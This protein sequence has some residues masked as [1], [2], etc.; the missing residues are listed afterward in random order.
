MFLMGLNHAPKKKILVSSSENTEWIWVQFCIWNQSSEMITKKKERSQ[1]VRVWIVNWIGVYT[2]LYI[3][4]SYWATFAFCRFN[5]NLIRCI[6]LDIS[7]KGERTFS[8]LFDILDMMDNGVQIYLGI[9]GVEKIN[10]FI[11]MLKNCT[12]ILMNDINSNH[13]IQDY[14]FY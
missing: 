7:S 12:G 2:H 10:Q 4:P 5:S 8:V 3:T 13:W 1:F 14:P 9:F 6:D 11:D